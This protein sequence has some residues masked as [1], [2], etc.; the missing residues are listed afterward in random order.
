MHQIAGQAPHIN[1]CVQ[2]VRIALSQA[3][4]RPI[5]ARV[6]FSF[7]WHRQTVRLTNRPR[8]RRYGRQAHGARCDQDDHTPGC[9][10]CVGSSK[11][12]VRQKSHAA[13]H[14]AHARQSRMQNR[15]MAGPDSPAQ[16]LAQ[17]GQENT[18]A[19]QAQ[20]LTGLFGAC[21]N[22]WQRGGD[23]D[24]TFAETLQK[25]QSE[26]RGLFPVAGRGRGNSPALRTGPKAAFCRL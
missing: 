13:C 19:M 7:G 25:A 24:H 16:A 18:R 11:L 3:H 10:F 6:G 1:M 4:T 15:P 2:L 9:S 8:E 5:S 22:R 17:A 14:L 20:G 26:T 12:P 23:H 21:R